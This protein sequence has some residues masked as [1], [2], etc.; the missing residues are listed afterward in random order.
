M[1]R[2]ED[3]KNNLAAPPQQ[4]CIITTQMAL[5][6][7]KIPSGTP[8]GNKI[9]TVI[10]HLKLNKVSGFGNL[11]P[12]IFK[13]YPHTMANILEPLLKRVWD[14]DQIPN[15]AKQGLITNSQRRVI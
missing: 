13:T 14:S 8:T 7:T 12:E 15:E 10:K 6:T 3:F 4:V 11:A 9:K 2:W 5:N 1:Y